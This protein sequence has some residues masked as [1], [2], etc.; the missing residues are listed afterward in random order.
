MQADVHLVVDVAD[1]AYIALDK[2]PIN[3]THVLIVS[4]EHYPNTVTL[5]E[6]ALK[7]IHSLI[8]GLQRAYASKGLQAVGFER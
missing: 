8:S 1:E 6:K 4:V 3:D 2:G 5:Q 7:E